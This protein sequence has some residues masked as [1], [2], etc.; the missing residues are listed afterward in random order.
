MSRALRGCSPRLQKYPIHEWF[1]PSYQDAKSGGC[2]SRR[3][4]LI[5]LWQ[6]RANAAHLIR[7]DL[8]VLNQTLSQQGEECISPQSGL[9]LVQGPQVRHHSSIFAKQ[10]PGGCKGAF[11]RPATRSGESDLSVLWLAHRGCS[12][13]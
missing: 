8:L 1:S 10:H 11:D 4:T 7:L 6:R 3:H 13:G 5:H 12:L 2:V 9:L